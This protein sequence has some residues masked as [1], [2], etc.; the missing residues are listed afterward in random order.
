MK[1]QYVS[2]LH[3]EFHENK[4][5]IKIHPIRPVGDILVL[6]GDILPFRLIDEYSYFF[7]YLSGNFK[8]TYWIP[9]NH[10]YY[11]SDLSERGVYLHETLRKNVFIVS[12]TSV[13]IEDTALHFSTLWTN[14]SPRYQSVIISGYSDFHAI[15]KQGE[16]LSISQYNLL[17]DKCVAFLNKVLFVKK[18]KTTIV[19]THH[20]PTFMS[21]PDKFS[22][23]PYNEAFAVELSDLILK[24]QPDFW[25]FGHEHCK[26]TDFEIGRTKLTSNP[27]GYITFNE[28]EGFEPGRVLDICSG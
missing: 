1:L 26:G 12:N 7:D 22:G 15:R 28:Q 14:I 18:A 24:T 6:A 25:I 4:E 21:Y 5:F 8:E 20:M 2:D 16:L 23:S 13:L 19:V 17:N 27:L 3:L 9:G 11:H 10:E